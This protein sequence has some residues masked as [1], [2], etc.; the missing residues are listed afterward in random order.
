MPEF[1][2]AFDWSIVLQEPYRDLLVTGV[3]VTLLL[4]IV[5]TITSLGFGVAA[6]IMR[7]TRIRSLRIIAGGYV[8]IVRNIPGLFW[9]LFFYFVFPELLPAGIGQQLN[10][11]AYYPI[12]AS[13][14]ALTID[15]A[16]YV[17]DIVLAGL[18]AIPAGQ[19]EAAVSTGL[20][21][22][23]QYRHVLLP[24]A[25]GKILAPLGVRMIHN[26]KNTALCMAI[27]TPELTWAT[28]QVESLT[29][30]GIEVTALAT[31]FYAVVAMLAGGYIRR[32]EVNM[33]ICGIDRDLRNE[34]LLWDI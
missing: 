12:V 22:L 20:T 30:R 29:F 3:L 34:A 24:Q 19:R 4:A 17:S 13:I 27:S 16:A 7:Q 21:R 11:Y 26:F 9:L 32:L 6:A 23:Q 1:R 18:R 2:Y 15:N 14:I 5:T 10:E 25:F 31:I 28:Q 33:R 8:E